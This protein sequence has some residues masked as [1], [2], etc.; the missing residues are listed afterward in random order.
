MLDVFASLSE[1]TIS[2]LKAAKDHL[3]GSM[4]LGLETS[5]SRMMKM[6]KDEIYFGSA[7]KIPEI[8]KGI[9]SVTVGDITAS[10][11]RF[12]RYG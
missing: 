3:K 5:E 1:V 7:V 9:D 4:I 10:A 11:A 8:T 2:E 12:F 6:A